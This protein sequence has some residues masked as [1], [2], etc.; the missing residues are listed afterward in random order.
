MSAPDL[1]FRRI[2]IRR[3]PGFPDGGFS[4]DDL[5]GGVNIVYPVEIGTWQ[6]DPMELRRQYGPEL[7]IIG[8]IDKREI[9]KGQAAIDAEIERRTP[10][11]REGGYVPAPDHDIIPGTSLHDYQYYLES[12]RALRF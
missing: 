6:T 1:A 5:C 11:M 8:G 9:A 3:M 2:D 4:V 10:L 7:R 12:I